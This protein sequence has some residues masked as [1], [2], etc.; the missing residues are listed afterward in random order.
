MHIAQSRQEA[1]FIKDTHGLSPVKYLEKVGILS[2]KLVAAHCT[3]TDEEDIKVLK[4]MHTTV[5]HCPQIYCK[6]GLFPPMENMYEANVK[7]A[8]GTGQIWTR[9][10]IC[11]LQSGEVG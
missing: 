1:K 11:G 10:T 8:L 3:V 9:G 4:E 5:A 2:E 7:A 6:R